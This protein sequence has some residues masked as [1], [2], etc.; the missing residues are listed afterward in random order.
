[1]QN[2]KT[3]LHQGLERKGRQQKKKRGKKKR[4]QSEQLPY[5]N[6]TDNMDGETMSHRESL[7]SLYI[8]N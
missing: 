5:S 3:K 4:H 6:M 8:S 7:I 2:C 1:M